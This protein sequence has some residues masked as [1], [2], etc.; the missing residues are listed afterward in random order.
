MQ[1]ITMNRRFRANPS[2]GEHWTGLIIAALVGM[3]ITGGAQLADEPV[4]ITF[5]NVTEALGLE[6]LHGDE[7]CWIDYN[8]DG[9]TDLQGGGSGAGQIFNLITVME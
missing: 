6:G 1:R 4:K 5:E 7:A 9:W 8:N 2:A 3:S